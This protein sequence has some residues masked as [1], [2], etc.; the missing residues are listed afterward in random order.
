MKSDIERA[1]SGG[2]KDTTVRSS[3]VA[4]VLLTARAKDVRVRATE[5]LK[6]KFLTLLVACM[7][8]VMEW[9]ALGVTLLQRQHKAS[10][11]QARQLITLR[12]IV[13]CLRGTERCFR[14]MKAIYQLQMRNL[15]LEELLAERAEKTD[16]LILLGRIRRTAQT[17]AYFL[18]DRN[19]IF[20]DP[21]GVASCANGVGDCRKV[22]PKNVHQTSG[23][24]DS[25]EPSSAGE[26]GKG[27]SFK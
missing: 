5:W 23:P 25:A 18:G 27:E 15:H 11:R 9:F 16:D 21:T 19:A 12:L 8:K 24:F 26:A 14:L 20:K 4:E 7:A 3:L 1:G 22:D 6:D 2:K 17:V 13:L 10:H